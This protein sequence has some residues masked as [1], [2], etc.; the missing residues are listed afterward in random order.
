MGCAWASFGLLWHL[1]LYEHGLCARKQLS[2]NRHF[3]DEADALAD[4]VAI[5]REGRLAASGPALAL[6][7]RYCDGMTLTVTTALEGAATDVPALERLLARHV[8]GARRLRWSGAELVRPLCDLGEILSHCKAQ[9]S[10][11]GNDAMEGACTPCMRCSQCFWFFVKCQTQLNCML[12]H[13]CTVT[14][15]NKPT[16]A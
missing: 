5:L 14:P 3:L 9:V 12:A 7:A 4:R 6:K 16:Y 8:A 10:Q 11:T 2:H 1:E 13:T 15:Y